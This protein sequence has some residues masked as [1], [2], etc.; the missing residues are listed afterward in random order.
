MQKVTRRSLLR[1]SAAGGVVALGAPAIIGRALAQSA[2]TAFAGEGMVVVAWSGSYE[3]LFHDTVVEPFNE[4]Y[5]TRIEIEGG[6]DQIVSKITSAPADNPPYDI[7]VADEYTSVT[8]L[9][10]GVFLEVDRSR[11]PN[12]EQVMPWFYETRP[13]AARKYGVPFSGGRNHL[14]V[15]AS[16]EIQP[17]SWSVLWD[18]RL[19][20]K[21]GLDKGYWWWTLAI[22][23]VMSDLA[24][25]IDE[26]YDQTTA[27][28]MFAKLEEIKVG[29]WFADGAEMVRL[30][31]SGEIDCAPVY[32][33]DVLSLQKDYPGEFTIGNPKE[34]SP[35]YV[36][37][38][39]KVRG[40]RHGDLADLFLDYMLSAE[41]QQRFLDGSAQFMA[42]KGLVAP[43][44]WEGYPLTNDDFHRQFSLLSMDG[45]KK[46]GDNYQWYDDR[47]KAAIMKTTG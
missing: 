22:P 41:A 27:E 19:A 16:Q 8:G 10:E 28:A 17:E 24:P 33:T 12:L 9:A 5:G 39:L 18:E 38:Y 45:W 4:K 32:S 46:I 36:D 7:T 37:W 47:L 11:F 13:E 15:R 25:G 40:T 3:G 23:A 44:H 34:G 2:D 1:L 30:L 43:A 14:L 26:I 21:V 35:T 29:R 42:R 6:W 31:K 20:G